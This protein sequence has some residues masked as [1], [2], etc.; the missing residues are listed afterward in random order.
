MLSF[1]YLVQPKIFRVLFKSGS[2]FRSKL[3]QKAIEIGLN[4]NPF[5]QKSALLVILKRNINA[6][7]ITLFCF[8]VNF[9]SISFLHLNLR[10]LGLI[11]LV[12][13]IIGL[14]FCTQSGNYWVDIFNSYA[15]SL[16][17]LII[18]FFEL[19]VVMWCYGIKK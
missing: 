11:S 10:L 15:G 1:V 5:E 8:I 13:C 14:M 17:L 12:S 3:N 2:N 9:C 16:P 18:V 19:V 6:N 4:K 7:S